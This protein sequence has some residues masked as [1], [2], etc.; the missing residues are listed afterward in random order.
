MKLDQTETEIETFQELV[1]CKPCRM[2]YEVTEEVATGSCPYCKFF[3]RTV[4]TG[5]KPLDL[6]IQQLNRQSNTGKN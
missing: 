4:N 2:Y 1:F 3:T 6:A 5:K